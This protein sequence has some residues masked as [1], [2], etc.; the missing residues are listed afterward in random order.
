MKS[1]VDIVQ[2]LRVGWRLALPI[3]A[4]QLLGSGILVAIGWPASISRMPEAPALFFQLW[5]GA[6]FATPIGFL[7]G[8]A[9]QRSSGQRAPRFLMLVCA[10]ASII[11]PLVGIGLV[12]S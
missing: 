4:A 8:T 9:F 5:L 3:V 7:I 6:A 1:K 2:E 11:L 12:S 10:A